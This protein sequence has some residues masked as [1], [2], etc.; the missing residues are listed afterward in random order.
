MKTNWKQYGIA[1]VAGFISLILE[2]FT[3]SSAVSTYIANDGLTIIAALFAIN[4]AALPSILSILRSIEANGPGIGFFKKTRKSAIRGLKETLI[5]GL[6][7]Y[8]ILAAKLNDLDLTFREHSVWKTLLAWTAGA[9]ARGCIFLTAYN[10]YDFAKALIS[11]SK[12]DVGMPLQNNTVQPTHDSVK[13]DTE[14]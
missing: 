11:M 1:L 2:Y 5:M 13:D 6:I 9:I 10:T 4:T 3:A 12:V 8:I 14:S 7:V